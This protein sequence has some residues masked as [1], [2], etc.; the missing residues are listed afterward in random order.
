M[1]GLEDSWKKAVLG[2]EQAGAR[3]VGSANHSDV[4]SSLGARPATGSRSLCVSGVC[5]YNY[6]TVPSALSGV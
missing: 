5:V 6:D 2:G 1:I 4:D 3:P